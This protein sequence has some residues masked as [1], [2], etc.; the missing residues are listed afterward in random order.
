MPRPKD[1][2]RPNALMTKKAPKPN[3][4][5]N[6]VL[7]AGYTSDL[8]C[9]FMSDLLQ[10]ADAIWCICDLVLHTELLP[11]TR[12]M[13][14]RVAIWCAIS[15][16]TAKWTRNRRHQ[17]ASTPNRICDLVKKKDRKLFL[18]DTKSQIQQIASAICS[19]SHM[20]S[21]T[22]NQPLRGRQGRPA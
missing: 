7:G 1:S 8:V 11:F 15:C 21:H 20:K 13:R 19:K 5:R 6:L 3:L 22:C 12:I 17:I 9:D 2:V 10:I 4:A 16:A 18:W 14:Y